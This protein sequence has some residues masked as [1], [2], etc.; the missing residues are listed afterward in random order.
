MAQR[1]PGWSA[2]PGR[3]LL[4][5]AHAS[6]VLP[7]V[8]LGRS[9]A[10]GALLVR[11]GVTSI[12]VNLCPAAA[13]NVLCCHPSPCRRAAPDKLG[14]L[15]VDVYRYNVYVYQVSHHGDLSTGSAGRASAPRRH[16]QARAISRRGKG[17]TVCEMRDAILFSL[18]SLYILYILYL[19][20]TGWRRDSRDSAQTS[21]SESRTRNSDVLAVYVIH[22]M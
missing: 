3:H 16:V 8:S 19:R 13:D 11:Q 18:L 22:G 14:A 2:E 9:R 5:R 12:P 6:S 10:G 15:T 4:A 7:L 20:P 1:G 21:D 17:L